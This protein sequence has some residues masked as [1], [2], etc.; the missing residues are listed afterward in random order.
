MRADAKI[1]YFSDIIGRFDRDAGK[2]YGV[3]VITEGKA[4]GHDLLVD[5]KTL[6]EVKNAAESFKDGRLKTKLNH[7][8]GVNL[9]LLSGRREDRGPKLQLI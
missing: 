6:M 8:S 5:S 4:R 2:I 7:R 1:T 3:S 9:S